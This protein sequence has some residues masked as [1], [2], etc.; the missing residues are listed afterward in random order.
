MQFLKA[1]K[2]I[3]ATINTARSAY[4]LLSSM[5]KWNGSKKRST[6]A[7]ATGVFTRKRKYSRKSTRKGKPKRR[8]FTSR[9]RNTMK[10]TVWSMK[11]KLRKIP[12]PRPVL[13]LDVMKLQYKVP[14]GS[15]LYT[16]LGGFSSQGIATP[17]NFTSSATDPYFLLVGPVNNNGS[18]SSLGR[19]LTCINSWKQQTK[20][21][22]IDNSPVRVTQIQIYCKN[23]VPVI[24]D[25][26]TAA[27]LASGAGTA[28]PPGL[29]RTT[30][31][32][33]LSEAVSAQY[34]ML[35]GQFP[36]LNTFNPNQSTVP[37]NAN[38][39]N[40]PGF[41]LTDS[42]VFN[43]H[44]KIVRC[45]TRTI[46]PGEAT[47]FITY[48]KKPRMIKE[49]DWIDALDVGSGLIYGIKY[50]AQKGWTYSIY[51]MES[52]P[53]SSAGGGTN[54]VTLGDSFLNIIQTMRWRS[55]FITQ[56]LSKGFN[57]SPVLPAATVEKLIYPGTS[58]ATAQAPAT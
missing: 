24:K 20:M 29:A 38:A 8:K 44:F 27:A 18:T 50:L 55:S 36:L 56:D 41:E 1:H 33:W 53:V 57:F 26:A 42:D 49:A 47:E 25:L 52:I 7:K 10:K 6:P 51:K 40:T 58:T 54:S 14:Q 16:G 45:R 48:S 34:S 23:N 2:W 22:N 13:M 11:K 12:T 31:E 3:P 46:Q 5:P 15:I 35:S 4:N 28:T 19:S 21:T 43:R 9:K 37:D 17:Y 32:G 30:F 39:T